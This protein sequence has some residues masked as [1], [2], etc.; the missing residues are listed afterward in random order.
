MKKIIYTLIFV[1][2]FSTAYSQVLEN[3]DRILFERGEKDTVYVLE[4]HVNYNLVTDQN[5]CVRKDSVSCRNLAGILLIPKDFEKQVLD[6]CVSLYKYEEG[7]E[8]FVNHL[9]EY[10]NDYL[11]LWQ[12][13]GLES[14]AFYSGMCK[15]EK[16]YREFFATRIFK[17]SLNI[18]VDEQGTVSFEVYE[19][20]DGINTSWGLASM[21]VSCILF[22]LFFRIVSRKEVM[23]SIDPELD[24]KYF[25]GNF[26]SVVWDMFGCILKSVIGG[27]II[28]LVFYLMNKSHYDPSV[29]WVDFSFV[30]IFLYFSTFLFVGTLCVY[31]PRAYRSRQQNIQERA[32]FI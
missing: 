28:A 13:K 8:I 26:L 19:W 3:K 5:G 31:I 18:L 10:C 20:L 17:R 23:F 29:T 32:K 15:R 7:G 4:E 22:I 14:K 30:N 6:S 25:K 12:N 21:L 24:S 27:V 16:S 1:F 11:Y 2:G 9:K